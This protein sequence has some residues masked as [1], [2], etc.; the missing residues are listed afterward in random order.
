MQ[1][2][3]RRG[4]V[5]AAALGAAAVTIAKPYLA[6]GQ[7]AGPFTQPPLPF[8]ED[9]LAPYIS[10]QTV[11]LHYGKHHKAYFDNLNKFTVGTPYAGMKLEEVMKASA[12]KPDDVRIFNNAG[13]A[14]NHIVYWDQFKPGG[15]KAPSG[16]LAAAIDKDL[17]GFQ[18]MKDKLTEASV[19]VFGSGWGWLAQDGDKLTIMSTPGGDNPVAKGKRALLGVDV[20]EHAYYLDYQNRRPDHVK[21]VLDNLVNWDYVR[22]R[23]A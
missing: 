22:D 6:F 2:F 1:T 3:S 10:A 21:A 9:A 20:W 17:G 12:G 18:A 5:R 8:K 16:K 15:A 13:Q 14:W 19:G 23:M 11:G 4:V 7:A